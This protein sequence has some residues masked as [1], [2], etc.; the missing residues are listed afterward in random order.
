MPFP[1]PGGRALARATM[2]GV[3]RKARNRP[4]RRPSPEELRELEERACKRKTRYP[5]QRQA[6]EAQA[7]VR[8]QYGHDKGIYQCKYCGGWHLGGRPLDV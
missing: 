7:L 8:L 3:G 1:D 5:N 6:L 4:R 2:W